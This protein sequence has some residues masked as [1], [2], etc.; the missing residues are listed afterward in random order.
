MIINTF[1]TKKTFQIQKG[2]QIQ[3]V[4]AR[5]YWENRAPLHTCAPPYIACCGRVSSN[6]LLLP[7]INI[8]LVDCLDSS[9]F[10]ITSRG[11]WTPSTY[12]ETFKTIFIK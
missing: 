11:V 7:T 2:F 12:L 3:I 10:T 9:Y 4:Y 5:K 6:T 1:Q 8:L